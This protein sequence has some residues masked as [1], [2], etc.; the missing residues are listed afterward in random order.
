M[1]LWKFDSENG[2]L[3]CEF[4]FGENHTFALENTFACGMTGTIFAW[5]MQK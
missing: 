3:Q 1:I 5:I 2:H 4:M